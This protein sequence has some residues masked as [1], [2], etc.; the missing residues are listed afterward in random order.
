MFL[1]LEQINKRNHLGKAMFQIILSRHW[2]RPVISRL[3][4]EGAKELMHKPISV[5]DLTIFKF[6]VKL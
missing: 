1:L 3:W 4:K 5:F 6:E 2:S